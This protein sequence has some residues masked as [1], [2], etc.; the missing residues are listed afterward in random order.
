M[1]NNYNAAIWGFVSGLRK[2]PLIK[3]LLKYNFIPCFTGLF[4]VSVFHL[5]YLYMKNKIDEWYDQESLENLKLLGLLVLLSS[6]LA[7]GIYLSLAITRH[8]SNYY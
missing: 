5:N 2:T 4:A 1:Y 6:T 7:F 8:Q 3:M